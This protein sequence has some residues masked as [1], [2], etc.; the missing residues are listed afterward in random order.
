MPQV[1]KRVREMHTAKADR[2]IKTAPKAM[3][4]ALREDMKD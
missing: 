4:A 1:L 2:V 3:R